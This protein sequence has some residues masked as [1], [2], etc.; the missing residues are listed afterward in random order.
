MTTASF[1]AWRK[2]FQTELK[3]KR[4]KEDEE[5]IR[6]LPP[7]ERDDYR[8]RRER[9]SGKFSLRLRLKLNGRRQ[10]AIRNVANIGD[11]G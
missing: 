9:L 7:K 4:D 5:R 2:G 1:D 3:A 10:T 11:F 8:R 6:A